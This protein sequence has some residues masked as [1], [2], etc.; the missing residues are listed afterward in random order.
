MFGNR[1]GEGVTAYCLGKWVVVDEREVER[2]GGLYAL[3]G[4]GR[5]FT[6]KGLLEASRGWQV[7]P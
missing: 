4:F 5:R 1:P 7:L 3:L 2:E 6:P